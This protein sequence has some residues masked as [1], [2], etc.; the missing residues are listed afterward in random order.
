MSAKDTIEW[1][2]WDPDAETWNIIDKNVLKT[3]DIPDGIEKMIGFEGR[4]DPASGY[5]CMYN[6]GRLVNGESDLGDQLARMAP[7]HADIPGGSVAA[8]FCGKA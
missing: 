3:A 7:V 2:V 5:Y 1:S 8:V 6:E 4:P